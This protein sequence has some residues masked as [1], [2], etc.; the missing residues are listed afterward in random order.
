MPGWASLFTKMKVIIAIILEQ[1]WVLSHTAWWKWWAL[2]VHGS[3]GLAS[4]IQKAEITNAP[5]LN[6]NM[7]TR[8]KFHLWPCVIG[9]SENAGTLKNIVWNYLQAMHINCVWSTIKFRVRTWVSS[10][11]YLIKPLCQPPKFYLFITNSVPRWSRHSE[12][13]SLTYEYL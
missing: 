9:C 8:G 1:E 3:T 4:L 10:S 11:R 12:R 6:T 2:L 7:T 5:S 13:T